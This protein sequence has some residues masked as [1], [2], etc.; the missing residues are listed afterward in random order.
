MAGVPDYLIKY[1][2]SML[3]KVITAHAAAPQNGY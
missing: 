1:M 3:N 2:L